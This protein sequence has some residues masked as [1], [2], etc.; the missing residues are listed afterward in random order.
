T[1]VARDD[2]D[3]Q[4]ALSP[5]R[6]TGLFVGPAAG[7]GPY[8]LR[9]DWGGPI[10]ETEDPY[11]FGPLLGELD[12]YLLAEGKHH[13]LAAC[14]GAHA[15]VV[16][17]VPGVRFAVWAPNARRVSVVGD[18]NTWDGRRH[19]MRLRHE[20]GVWEIFVPRLR[21]G[22]RYKYELLGPH[23]ELLPLKADPH[24]EQSER[25]PGTASVV[26]APSRHSWQDD[27]WMAD[28]AR[29]NDREAPISIYEVHLGSWS[30]NVDQGFRYL[31]Y[32]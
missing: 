4:S 32:P 23:G 30:R 15:M 13:D 10:Q 29:H 26:P 31:T 16:D 8:V 20:A 27:G 25:P 12:V 28:R 11:S 21:V 17:G 6:Q 9:I 1:V 18:F 3:R 2:P 14:L 22:A 7:P 24:A 19:P 5:I